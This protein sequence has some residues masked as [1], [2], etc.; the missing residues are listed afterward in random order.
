MIIADVNT[1]CL[2]TLTIVIH[3]ISHLRYNM[4]WQY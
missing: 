2:T 1:I 4:H 3:N